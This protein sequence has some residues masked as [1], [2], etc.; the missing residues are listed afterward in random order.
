M[1]LRLSRIP[2]R[3]ASPTCRGGPPR[4]PGLSVP[5][6][7]GTPGEASTGLRMLSGETDT[8]GGGALTCSG[9]DACGCGCCCCWRCSAC[10][11]SCCCCWS[12]CWLCARSCLFWSCSCLSRSFAASRSSSSTSAAFSAAAFSRTARDSFSS[13]PLASSL[14]L[15]ASSS[16]LFARS[17]AS[18]SAC[19]IR[20]SSARVRLS[21]ASFSSFILLRSRAAA[22]SAAGAAAACTTASSLSFSSSERFASE[23][24]ASGAVWLGKAARSSEGRQRPLTLS[25]HAPPAKAAPSS[26]ASAL[27]VAQDCFAQ[28]SQ[29]AGAESQREDPEGMSTDSG[30]MGGALRSCGVASCCAFPISSLSPAISS[31][32]FSSSFFRDSARTAQT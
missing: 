12:S 8:A 32:A 25:S 18:S 26:A 24:T 20:C 5:S 17:S 22:S 27:H 6:A 13:A 28:S 4:M 19:T 29:R 10:W 9:V 31:R 14:H 15:R 30:K 7:R 16:T 1:A 3:R 23:F 11:S 2:P 21:T